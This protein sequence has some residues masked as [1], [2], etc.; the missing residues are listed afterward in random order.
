[1][2]KYFLWEKVPPNSTFNLIILG[3]GWSWVGEFD[4]F[5]IT[6]TSFPTQQNLLNR[7]NT[8]VTGNAYSTGRSWQTGS[9]TAAAAATVTA[10]GGQQKTLNLSKPFTS[11][12]DRS[13]TDH[14]LDQNLPLLRC[15]SK[16]WAHQ[17]QIPNLS[18]FSHVLIGQIMN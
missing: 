13:S 11:R 16:A 12:T 17:Q 6:F 8:L 1:M 2:K 3:L 4:G 14:D 9:N 7:K 15:C 10:W 18:K 5:I